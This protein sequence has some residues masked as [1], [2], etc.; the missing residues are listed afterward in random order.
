MNQRPMT[1]EEK[2]ILAIFGGT[3]E[4]KERA[5]AEAAAAQKA[6][7]EKDW[8]QAEAVAEAANRE[9]PEYRWFPALSFGW[10]AHAIAIVEGADGQ[11]ARVLRATFFGTEL[12]YYTPDNYTI[13]NT[14][15]KG[16]TP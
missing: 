2:L 9:F 7:S 10:Q 11:P 15:I 5:A 14:E 3:K 1:P 12:G 8:A 4:Q 6:Q 13:D 16:Y